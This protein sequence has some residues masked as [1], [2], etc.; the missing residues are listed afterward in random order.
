MYPHVVLST[1]VTRARHSRKG[2]RSTAKGN[3]E[4]SVLVEKH[5]SR[6]VGTLD[7]DLLTGSASQAAIGIFDFMRVDAHAVRSEM[8]RGLKGMEDE[9]SKFGTA[10]D[11][12]CLNYVLNMPAGR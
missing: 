10:V 2:R 3:E 1:H 4:P 11:K 8:A 9:F 12:E 5:D 6:F 7:R